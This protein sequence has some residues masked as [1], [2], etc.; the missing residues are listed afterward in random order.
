MTSGPHGKY[1]CTVIAL[2]RPYSVQ[3]DRKG[4]QRKDAKVTHRIKQRDQHGETK[5]SSTKL[6]PK[7]PSTWIFRSVECFCRHARPKFLARHK[8]VSPWLKSFASTGESVFTLIPCT[9][10][11]IAHT[12]I[13]RSC[14]NSQNSVSWQQTTQCTPGPSAIRCID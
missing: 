14:S 7:A 8:A 2:T 5:F 4:R 9:V 13:P 6:G 1:Q 12:N 11:F 10:S 3:H